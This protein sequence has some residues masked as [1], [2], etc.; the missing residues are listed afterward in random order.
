MGG[1]IITLSYNFF[2]LA[3]N[4]AIPKSLLLSPVSLSPQVPSSAC[5][6]LFSFLSW[7]SWNSSVPSLS[8]SLFPALWVIPCQI[9]SFLHHSSPLSFW[10]LLALSHP[11][12][13][14]PHL[15][16]DHFPAFWKI[17]LLYLPSAFFL[18]V[19]PLPV[20]L[21]TSCLLL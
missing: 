15:F 5:W 12:L 2:I 17:I 16:P 9:V 8:K 18:Q 13:L 3:G 14:R 4:P 11:I 20:F 10:N 7:L 19:G 1:S 21:Q 6:V